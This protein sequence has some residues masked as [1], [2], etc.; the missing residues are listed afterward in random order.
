[1]VT[2]DKGSEYRDRARHFGLSTDAKPDAGGNGSLFYEIDTG[3]TYI[4]D[5]EN[6]VWYPYYGARGE[7]KVI[8]VL[9]TDQKPTNVPNG[10][11]LIEMDTK[12]IYFF[13]ATNSVWLE[14]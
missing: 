2:Y 8:C 3:F 13:D 12:K 4:F 1:M 9:S 6:K 11:C 10:A 5:A 14:F 7:N